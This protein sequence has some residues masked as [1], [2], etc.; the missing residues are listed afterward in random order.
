MQIKN[1]QTNDRTQNFTYDELNRIQTAKT[2]ATSGPHCWGET[3]GYD[4]WGSL[5]S[6]GAVPGYTGCMQENLTV[7]VTAN[8]QI[9]GF[10][11]DAAGNLTATPPPATLSYTY[12]AE[13]RLTSTAGVTYSYD[14]DGKRVSK[15]TRT[16]YW[17]GMAARSTS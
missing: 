17:Y 10:A 13:N 5:L 2:Q 11:Y 9:S 4:I 3:F 16:L 14:G 7:S 1:N 15:S 12:D 6:I 8:N